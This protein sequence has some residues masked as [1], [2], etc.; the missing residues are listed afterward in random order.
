MNLK[1]H[2]DLDTETVLTAEGHLRLQ[3]QIERRAHELWRAGGC[4]E[5]TAMSDWLR[6]EREVLEQHSLAYQ[7]RAATVPVAGRP[8]MVRRTGAR[9]VEPQPAPE[10]Y[11]A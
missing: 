1:P 8:R 4:R 2:T 10:R 6:A 9:H 3:E 5:G 11:S 7:R